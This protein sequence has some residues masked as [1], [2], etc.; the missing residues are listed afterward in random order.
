MLCRKSLTSFGSAP[1]NNLT[2]AFG[3]H[4]Y[5]ETV[6]SLPFDFAWLKCP[7]HTLIPFPL[8]RIFQ[9]QL[10]QTRCLYRKPVHLV[11]SPNSCLKGPSPRTVVG[12]N[13]RVRPGSPREMQGNHIGLP[14]RACSGRLGMTGRSFKSCITQALENLFQHLSFQ[15]EHTGSPLPFLLYTSCKLYYPPEPAS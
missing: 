2:S 15:G 9:A 13:L 14:L 6:S 12:A 4:S 3:R 11:K 5:K 8:F 10:S 7:F 1:F